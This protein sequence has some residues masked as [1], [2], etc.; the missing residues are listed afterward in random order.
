MERIT[1]RQVLRP[2]LLVQS[3]IG[4][5]LAAIK[6]FRGHHNRGSLWG[7]AGLAETGPADAAFNVFVALGSMAFAYSFV[8]SLALLSLSIVHCLRHASCIVGYKKLLQVHSRS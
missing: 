6:A 3:L 1:R 7:V 4:L 8:R 5:V 2:I